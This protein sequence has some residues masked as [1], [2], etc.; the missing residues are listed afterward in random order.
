MTDNT[1][2]CKLLT[3]YVQF[4]NRNHKDK[5]QINNKIPTIV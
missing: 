4:T 3:T 5:K 1:E 2:Q